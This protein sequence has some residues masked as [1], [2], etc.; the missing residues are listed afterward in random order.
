MA[1][2]NDGFTLIMSLNIPHIKCFLSSFRIIPCVQ[3]YS[4]IYIDLFWFLKSVILRKLLRLY[5]DVI[6]LW[7]KE[8]EKSFYNHRVSN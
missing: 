6:E 7:K 2:P 8:Y 1:T 3:C 4:F 5:D